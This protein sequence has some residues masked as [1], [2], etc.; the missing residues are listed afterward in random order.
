MIGDRADSEEEDAI[1]SMRM[2]AMLN[3]SPAS[4]L[5]IVG[6]LFAVYVYWAPSTILP[7]L[8]WFAC[9]AAIACTNLLS[10]VLYARKIPTSWTARAWARF[11]SIMHL[12][13]G[14]TWGVGGG[15][16]LSFADQHQALLTISIGLAAV[17]VSIPSVVHLKAYNLFHLPIFWS[18]AVGLVFSSLQFNWL[19]ATG[20]FLLG[21]FAVLIGRSLGD[22][23]SNALRLSIENK[24]LA[25]R[26]EERSAALEAANRDLEIE[27]LTDPLT[28]VANR[29]RLMSFARAIRGRCA[30][31]VVDIDHFKS[32]NDTFGHVEGDTCLVA[33][34]ETLQRSVRPTHDLVA[35]LGGEEFAIVLND[36]STVE[37]SALAERMRV[38]VETLKSAR[39]GRIRRQVTVSLGFATRAADQKKSLTTLMEEADAAVYRAKAGGR[40]RV[41]GDDAAPERNVA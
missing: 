11:V 31:L 16:M 3:A 2:A 26:L 10:T 12:L 32:Y 39:R 9:I 4:F 22:Q 29:R 36:V 23:L 8:V 41:C 1:L 27:N 19:I 20:F 17:T 13:S 14:L 18:Y 37:A 7:L 5:S 24:R 21:A 38:N 6:A 35:R 40:N 28:G 34:A 33:V 15:W 25:E 30:I